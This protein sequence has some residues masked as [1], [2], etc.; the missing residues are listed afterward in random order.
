M[1]TLCC[2]PIPYGGDCGFTLLSLI[3]LSAQVITSENIILHQKMNL[4]YFIPIKDH[5]NYEQI[6]A[7][8]KNIDINEMISCLYAQSAIEN[9][10]TMSESLMQTDFQ[11]GLQA[12]FCKRNNGTYS[13][14]EIDVNDNIK[15]LSLLCQ[16]QEHG[17]KQENIKKRKELL[18]Q[19]LCSETLNLVT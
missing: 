7:A 12:M 14:N 10:E 1:S 16:T 15:E 13:V 6:K 11:V 8:Y 18:V 4:D 19:A 3:L 9:E 2:K 17:K 5:L